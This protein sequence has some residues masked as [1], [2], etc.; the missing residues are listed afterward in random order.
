MSRTFF[1]PWLSGT[2]PV[3]M[4][5]SHY[6]I[7]GVCM[8]HKGEKGKGKE[9]EGRCKVL[10]TTSG[11][12][13]DCLVLEAKVIGSNMASNKL[14]AQHSGYVESSF[15]Q[16]LLPI[17]NDM[18]KKQEALSHTVGWGEDA[19]QGLGERWKKITQILE[20]NHFNFNQFHVFCLIHAAEMSMPKKN[21]IPSCGN[22][23]LF[24]FISKGKHNLTTLK[25]K[26][27]SAHNLPLVEELRH[28]PYMCQL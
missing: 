28:G 13:R 1:F 25:C 11:L 2:S 23:W 24:A 6:I 27:S 10:S 22:R 18:L 8:V 4:R 17:S 12:P 9:N 5:P 14:A 7:W 15:M 16:V 19:G 3:W 20:A 21:P 26:E